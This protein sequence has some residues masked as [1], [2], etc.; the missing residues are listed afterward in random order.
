MELEEA[1]KVY[2]RI[3]QARR[4]GQ[5]APPLNREQGATLIPG[6]LEKEQG[7]GL[8]PATWPKEQ[9]SEVLLRSDPLEEEVVVQVAEE[10]VQGNTGDFMSHK[11]VVQGNPGDFMGHKEVVQ[12]NPDDFRRLSKNYGM[13]ETSESVIDL[14][15][16]KEMKAKKRAVM[17]EVVRK[18]TEARKEKKD[19]N[20]IP[21][22]TATEVIEILDTTDD[23]IEAQAEYPGVMSPDD[24]VS[25]V[26]VDESWSLSSDDDEEH[27]KDGHEKMSRKRSLTTEVEHSFSKRRRGEESEVVDISILVNSILLSIIEGL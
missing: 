19:V 9:E 7:V 23:S 11:E 22:N 13:K 5:E 26:N 10:V 1:V 4:K 17:E 27:E 25:S 2:T 14:D 20:N 21:A 16:V 18:A 6:V 3:L 24:N 8:S 12:G 15:R